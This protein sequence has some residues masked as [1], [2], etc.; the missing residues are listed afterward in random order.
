MAIKL[1]KG[2]NDYKDIASGLGISGETVRKWGRNINYNPT[3]DILIQLKCK[4]PGTTNAA[5][6]RKLQGAN[7]P[8]TIQLLSKFSGKN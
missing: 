1:D 3:K 5:L 4:K 2:A 6:K 8:E 7:R